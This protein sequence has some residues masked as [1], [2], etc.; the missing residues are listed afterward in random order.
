MKIECLVIRFQ[1]KFT[2]PYLTQPL[3]IEYCWNSICREY[4]GAT[5]C[6]C[7]SWLLFSVIMT[8]QGQTLIQLLNEDYCLVQ[9][10]RILIEYLNNIIYSSRLN[11]NRVI[12]II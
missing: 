1:L 3:T 8:L 5:K 11:I 9:S 2:F 4:K 12:T 10:L 7:N 6:L